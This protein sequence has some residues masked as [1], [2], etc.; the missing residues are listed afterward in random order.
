MNCS[1]GRPL[2]SMLAQ[3]FR[4]PTQPPTPPPFCGDVG[5]RLFLFFFSMAHLGRCLGRVVG[6]RRHPVERTDGKQLF[7]FACRSSRVPSPGRRRRPNTWRRVRRGSELVVRRGARGRCVLTTRPM[8]GFAAIAPPPPNGVV[9]VRTKLVFLPT[10]Q[11][12]VIVLRNFHK[13]R[14]ASTASAERQTQGD[15]GTERKRKKGKGEREAQCGGAAHDANTRAAEWR[16]HPPQR[17]GS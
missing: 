8:S 7:F 10:S 15:S 1:K 4:A 11:S 5:I 17:R 2:L 12:D 16:P 6:A 3:S 9:P 14:K 13:R